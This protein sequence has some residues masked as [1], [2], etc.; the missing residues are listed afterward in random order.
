M[1]KITAE[2][3]LYIKL[4]RSG[5]W[6]SECINDLNTLRLGFNEADFDACA[7]SDW[8]VVENNFLSLDRSQIASTGFV[9]QIKYFFEEPE[10]TIWITFYDNKLWWTK[11]K[12]K[13][14]LNT[15]GTKARECVDAWSDRDINGDLLHFG[16]ISGKL[17]KTQ[18]FRG[19]ICSV[20]EHAYLL[21]KINAEESPKMKQTM[22]TYETL[23][24]N[25]ASL[26]PELTWQDFEVLVDLIF[27]Q[28]GWQRVSSLGK[29]AK[30]ID[31]D[32]RAPVTGEKCFVQVKSSSNEK[33][34]RSYLEKVSTWVHYDKFYYVCHTFKGGNYNELKGLDENLKLILVDEVAELAIDSGLTK[35]IIERV[36]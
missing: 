35:W 27:T 2:R 22:S 8:K 34:F 25:I 14:T 23:K 21:R 1:K 16:A 11:A 30:T 17:L 28:A 26:I 7:R 6:E 20:T 13:V 31:L 4:G 33:E 12:S 15:D 36:S 3:S 18:G 9:T 24:C 10:D 29:T 19:T 5:K 32:L